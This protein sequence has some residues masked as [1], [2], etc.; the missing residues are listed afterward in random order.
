ALFVNLQQPGV[1]FVTQ[2][3][4]VGEKGQLIVGMINDSG[5]VY[6]LIAR[7]QMIFVIVD[8]IL[9]GRAKLGATLR[10]FRHVH[11]DDQ[12]REDVQC[13]DSGFVGVFPDLIGAPEA[14][15]AALAINVDSLIVVIEDVVGD[16]LDHAAKDR[17]LFLVGDEIIINWIDEKMADDF[18]GAGVAFPSPA[19]VSGVVPYAVA[20]LLLDVRL[21]D[22]SRRKAGNS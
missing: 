4:I 1:F 11:G 16:A 19:L 6:L 5:N 18:I 17:L 20:G 9:V 3:R 2:E 15:E 10:V 7:Q 8:Q 21:N 13:P 22:G 14:S 12:M